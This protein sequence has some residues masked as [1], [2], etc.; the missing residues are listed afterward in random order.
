LKNF[1]FILEVL[2]LSLT[3]FGGPAGHIRLFINIFVEKYKYIN[4]RDF[5]DLNSFTQ[6]LPGASSTQ[7]LC[8]IAFRLGGFPL[9][10]IA[11]FVWILPSATILCFLALIFQHYD[12]L[13]TDSHLFRYLNPMVIS[14]MIL[15]IYRTK[16]HYISSN[17]SKPII[18]LNVLIIFLFFKHPF[19]IPI[20]FLINGIIG[21]F[22]NKRKDVSINNVIKLNN[23]TKSTFLVFLF[24]FLSLAIGSEYARK[25][26]S[27]HRYFFNLAEHNYR[28]GST[29]YGGGDILI[30][31]LYEQYVARPT[32]KITKKRNP[33]VLQLQ[34]S[35]V[36]TGAGM[37]RLLPGPLFSITSFTAPLLFKSF[38][39]ERQ[40]LASIIA[41]FFLFLPGY[42]I[43]ISAYDPWYQ[44]KKQIKFE[45][46]F[47][48]LNHTVYSLLIASAI[49]FS[50][51]L[52]RA[53]LSNEFGLITL[54]FE[55]ILL[56]ILQLKF[57]I[58]HILLVFICITIGF[59]HEFL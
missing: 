53:E 9:S 7:L 38:S 4:E 29:I 33:N 37:I 35:D 19:I 23:N 58:N 42:L 22:Y 59:I 49:H 34:S 50:I 55:L 21:Y 2:K 32:A 20:L 39:T 46:F 30:P 48:G 16:V 44:Y 12:L 24:I 26:G 18:L 56:V 43:A 45:G 40:I 8:L 6:L 1:P 36:M 3:S 11:L 47:K 10:L 14:F 57:R 41:T 27:E 52:F 25:N 31:M 15:L 51:E 5:H 28:L 17:L 13:S 54:M